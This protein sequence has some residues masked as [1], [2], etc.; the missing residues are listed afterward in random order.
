MLY[1]FLKTILN[2]CLLLSWHTLFSVAVYTTDIR[3]VS[4][5]VAFFHADERPIL[6]AS[7]LPQL[8][9]VMYGWVFV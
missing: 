6:M 4:W 7:N 2:V 8:H 3:Q 1:K 5:L 9:V